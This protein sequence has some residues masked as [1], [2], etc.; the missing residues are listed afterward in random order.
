MAD[1][2][3]SPPGED[4]EWVNAWAATKGE[5]HPAE[6][7][8]SGAAARPENITSGIRVV[9]AD[10]IAASATDASPNSTNVLPPPGPPADRALPQTE[11][12][13]PLRALEVVQGAELPPA[14]GAAEFLVHPATRR[15]FAGIR[16]PAAAAEPIPAS[17]EQTVAPPAER[18]EPAANRASVVTPAV[19][20]STAP[21]ALPDPLPS[22]PPVMPLSPA[23][24]LE[25][26]IADIAFAQD[27]LSAPQATARSRRTRGAWAAFRNAESVP[28]L[29]GSVVGATLLIV[30][31]AAASLIRLR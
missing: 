12:A 20:A 18:A 15:F 28:I 2:L 23:E 7:P 24:Q 8:L 14:R 1:V 4:Y 19:T 13:A 5:A 25:R 27:A 31:G 10:L 26:D 29:V 17:E 30:F 21:T 16:L 6:P 3:N 9:A 22:S 11:A